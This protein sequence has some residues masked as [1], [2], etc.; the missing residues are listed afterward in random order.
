V[1]AQR[2]SCREGEAMIN[3]ARLRDYFLTL[4]QIDSP[5]R[6]EAAIARRLMD[7]LAAL[8]IPSEMDGASGATGG[9]AGNVIARVPGTVANARPL[10]LSSHMDTVNPGKGVKPRVEG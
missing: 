3:T 5:S 7:D 4:V 9:D 6:E 2:R 10:F 1:C 8:G